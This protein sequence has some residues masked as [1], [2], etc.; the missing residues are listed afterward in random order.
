MGASAGFRYL[1]VQ[2][3]TFMNRYDVVAS[4]AHE[5]QHAN[6]IAQHPE[7]ACEA[8]LA[9]LYRR[10]GDEPEWCMFETAEAQRAE[11]TVRAEILGM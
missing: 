4:L 3:K 1:R 9:A 2:I 10:I 8:S 6:E 11:R 5:M 7:V